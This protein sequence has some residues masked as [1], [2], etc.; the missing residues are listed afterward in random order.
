MLLLP[1]AKTAKGRGVFTLARSVRGG[2][3]YADQ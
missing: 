3:G 1:S 2:S